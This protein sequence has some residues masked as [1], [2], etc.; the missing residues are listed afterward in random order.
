MKLKKREKRKLL[1]QKL[2]Y[3]KKT[4]M[5]PLVIPVAKFGGVVMGMAISHWALVQFYACYC[6][7]W[8]IFGPFL[9]ILSLGSPVCQFANYLQFEIARNYITIWAATGGA[10]IAYLFAN[11]KNPK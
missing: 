4:L 2:S 8:S 6:A 1:M 3:I 7:P 9:T 5:H 10:V 11:I